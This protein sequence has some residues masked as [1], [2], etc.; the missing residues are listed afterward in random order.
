MK[1]QNL[2]N[3]EKQA[4][5]H[6][7]AKGDKLKDKIN[8]AQLD[9]APLTFDD[10]LANEKLSLMKDRLGRGVKS[11]GEIMGQMQDFRDF[12]NEMG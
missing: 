1:N 3:L 4:E 10:Y 11:L 8:R 5:K 6:F 12:Q 2:S 9:P 7:G